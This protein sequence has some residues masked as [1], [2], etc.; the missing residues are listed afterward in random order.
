MK[1]ISRRLLDSPLAGLVLV[2]LALVVLLA[3]CSGTHVDNL[4]G[5]TVNNF[6][7]ADNL[8]QM[9]VRP[10]FFAI[11]AV[12]TTMVIISGGIDLS[13]G[14]IYALAGVGTAMFL[15]WMTAGEAGAAAHP[16]WF[17]FMMGLGVCLAIGAACG[18]LNGLLK[19]GL[20]VHPFIISMGTMLI[21]RTAAFVPSKAESIPLPDALVGGI[22]ATLGLRAGLNPV[23]ALIMLATVAAGAVF[24]S[25]TVPGR[26]IYAVGGNLEASRFS[27]IRSGRVLVGVYV[28][29]G[30]SA[31]LAAFVGCSFYGAASCGDA[32]GYE[33]F[34][35]A[36][37]VVGGASLSGGRGGAVGAM[38]GAILIELIRKSITTLRFDQ[39]Y[40]WGIVG[41]AIVLAVVLDQAS[42]K[43][44]ARRLAQGAEA[45][46]DKSKEQR[47]G[48]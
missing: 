15:R 11:M 32:S 6:L 31:A 40:E 38:F 19:V 9:S 20:G 8:F 44:T 25:R 16:A 27:G 35:I 18:L 47:S 22:K 1:P 3:S 37:A 41:A 26:H 24:L 30:L 42:A 28:F 21:F 12:G 46:A 23:P 29:S 4:S 39:N 48:A 45:P 34:A 5:E 17:V 36:S 14:S 43:W 33:L 2:N 10:S 13:V 7:N